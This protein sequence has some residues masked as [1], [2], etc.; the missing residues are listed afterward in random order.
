[1]LELFVFQGLPDPP[2]DILVEPG[3]QDGTLLV[4]WHPVQV[5]HHVGSSVTGYAV[6]ADGKKVITIL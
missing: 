3:P 1:M 2:S 6:F 4:T 5:Q